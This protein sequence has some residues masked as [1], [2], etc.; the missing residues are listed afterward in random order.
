MKVSVLKFPS[1]PFTAPFLVAEPH[2]LRVARTPLKS[3]ILKLRS[4]IFSL[5]SSVQRQ[6]PLPW[7]SLVRQQ[8][9]FAWREFRQ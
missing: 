6:A 3:F 2:F 9:P 7:Q 1:Q 5:I 4:L 8:V